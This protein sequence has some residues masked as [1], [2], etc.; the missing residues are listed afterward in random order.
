MISSKKCV[1]CYVGRRPCKWSICVQNIPIVTILLFGPLKQFYLNSSTYTSKVLYYASLQVISRRW[2]LFQPYKFA[3]PLCYYRTHLKLTNM[4][5]GCLV[6]HNVYIQ[7]REHQCSS[8]NFHCGQARAHTHTHKH[9]ST[10]MCVCVCVCI[11]IYMQY[12]Q[13]HTLN[14]HMHSH[15]CTYLCTL[16]TYIHTHACIHTYTHTHTHTHICIH[17]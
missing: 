10:C 1:V 4:A 16:H 17:T 8:L 6:W 15:V 2:L 5:L 12:T 11:Y 14:T 9:I 3:C 7:V 13:P